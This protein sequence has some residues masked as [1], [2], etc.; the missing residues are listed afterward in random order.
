MDTYSYLCIGGYKYQRILLILL[1]LN[2]LSYYCH[3]PFRHNPKTGEWAHLTRLTRFPER[4]WLSNFKLGNTDASASSSALT[5][6]QALESIWHVQSEEQLFS[7]VRESVEIELV[8]VRKTFDKKSG[9]RSTANVDTEFQALESLRWFV[10]GN[11]VISPTWTAAV[12]LSAPTG[13]FRHSFSLRMVLNK[14]YLSQV[15]F[16]RR[17]G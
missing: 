13:L 7:L 8:K 14:E 6:G 5:A 3:A 2:L 12:S 11:D 1:D 15:P 17:G 4:K 16:S 9:V 10:V